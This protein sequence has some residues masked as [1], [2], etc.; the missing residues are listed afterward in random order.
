MVYCLLFTYMYTIVNPNGTSSSINF[1][2]NVYET[3]FIISQLTGKLLLNLSFCR[4]E[5]LLNLMESKPAPAFYKV[6]LTAKPTTE[7]PALIG[8]SE[9]AVLVKVTTEVTVDNMEISIIDKDQSITAK[10]V[11]YVVMT[12]S[13]PNLILHNHW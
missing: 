4:T 7:N 9:G 6:S 1:C 5:Y 10:T 11:K 8:L 12:V 13:L 3:F 2:A